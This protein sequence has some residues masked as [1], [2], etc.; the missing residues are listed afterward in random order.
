MKFLSHSSPLHISRQDKKFQSSL[1]DEPISKKTIDIPPRQELTDHISSSNSFGSNVTL[2][3]N[4][5]DVSN[6]ES[7]QVDGFGVVSYKSDAGIK[8]DR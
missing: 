1:S 4:R 2:V 6:C 8:S 5:I 7:G 3:G